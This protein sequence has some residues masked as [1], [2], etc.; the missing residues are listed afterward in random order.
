MA[1][2]GYSCTDAED[3]EGN[4]ESMYLRSVKR[5]MPFT[6]GELDISL[7]CGGYKPQAALQAMQL[8]RIVED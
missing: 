8:Q 5:Y 3:R 2:N 7:Q 1:V 4:R 6:C